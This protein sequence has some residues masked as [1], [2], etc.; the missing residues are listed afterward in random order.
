MHTE[1]MWRSL[2]AAG[3][4]HVRI[5]RSHPGWDVYDS[6][7]V[8]EHEGEI[9]RGGYTLILDKEFR[10]LEVRIMAEQEPG[11]MAAL[12][13]LAS[14]DGTWT[15]ADE[16]RIPSMDGV[17]DVDIAWSPLT[18][19]LPVRRLEL[20]PGEETSVPVAYIDLPSLV[21]KRA[22]QFYTRIDDS[23]VRFETGARDF[24]REISFDEDGFVIEYPDLF[25][26][27]FP[28]AADQ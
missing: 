24:A 19:M 17:I 12:H 15:D 4:E 8:R 27:A 13:L 6:M 21:L 28:N 23:K 18:N 25:A 20:N 9:R 3:F 14:G 2:D 11:G 26:R 1:Y 22:E 16:R 7:I 10:T 5:D